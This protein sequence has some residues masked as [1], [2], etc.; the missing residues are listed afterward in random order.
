M[1]AVAFA[2]FVACKA[3]SIRGMPR[4]GVPAWRRTAYTCAWPGLDAGTFW[5]ARKTAPSPGAGEWMFAI[6]KTGI[7]LILLFAVAR[8][9]PAARPITRGWIGMMGLVMSLHFGFF[10]LLSCLWRSKGI[11]AR[12]LMDWP[13]RA[14][15][16]SDFW[17]RRWN[18][19]FR[20]FTHRF[21]FRPM[22]ER[23]GP[24]R[25]VIAGFL[26]SGLI[27]DLVVSVPAGGG[28]GGPTLF[29][30]LQGFGLLAE[31]SPTG[32]S[33]GLCKG[34]RGR[35]FAF[36]ILLLPA[37]WLFHRPFILHIILPFLHAIG[38]LP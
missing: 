3:I 27:H 9:V 29:F 34:W 10:H 12:P 21:L 16:L 17:G 19:A 5:D 30:L 31:R 4:A 26:F 2:V 20:D 38:A 7:G 13:I 8:Y 28:Y 11:A 14:T 6:A 18:T 15:G 1:W 22:S 35:M 24:R 37:G 33:I 23:L 25:A 36:A 32:R